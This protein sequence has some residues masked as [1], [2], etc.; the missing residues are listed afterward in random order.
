M[1]HDKYNPDEMMER[2]KLMMNY[3]SSKTLNENRLLLEQYDTEY[4]NEIAKQFMK[5]PDKISIKSGNPTIDVNK[6]AMAFYKTIEGIGRRDT[7]YV[8]SKIFTSLPNSIGV[9]KAY[10]TV[11]KESIYDAIKGEY[12]SGGFMDKVVYAISSQIK[13]WCSVENNK[14]NNICIVKSKEQLKY[15]I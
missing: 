12:F 2:I 3:D 8:V 7:D 4:F 6:S 13:E 10:P 1:V 9:L 5:Y 11:G 15:G 14:K